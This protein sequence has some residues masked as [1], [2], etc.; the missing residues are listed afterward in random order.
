MQPISGKLDPGIT[1]LVHLLRREGFDTF[2]SCQGGPGHAFEHPTVR[3]QPTD[4][5]K[6]Q[7][8]IDRL[9]GVL[10]VNGYGGYYLKAVYAYQ[11]D[12]I[13]WQ[14]PDNPQCFI[15]I[16]FWLYF[17]EGEQPILL[18]TDAYLENLGFTNSR[19]RGIRAP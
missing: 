7:P 17:R 1:D 4:P 3:I 14:V 15:E 8:E 11:N 16:E 9:A 12:K 18:P 10:S 19:P 13:P 5:H 6:M 2:T